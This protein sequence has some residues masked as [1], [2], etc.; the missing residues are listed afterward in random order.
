[1]QVRMERS[2]GWLYL[3]DPL[4]DGPRVAGVEA[5]LARLVEDPE[6]RAIVVAG[7]RPDFCR[8]LDPG[9]LTPAAVDG[10]PLRS[11][12]A[13]LLHLCEA[14]LPTVAAVQGQA[15]GGGVGLAAA[16]DLVLAEPDATFMLPE[17]ILGL[18]PEL[19]GPFVSR[20]LG[21]ART[22]Y[23][24]LSSRGVHAAEAQRIGLVDEVAVDGLDRAVRTQLRR[25]LRSSPRALA[26]CKR[27]LQDPPLEELRAQ[28]A[29]AV[30]HQ[31]AWLKE[32]EGRRG[33]EAF[34]RGE[35]PP[36]FQAGGA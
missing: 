33:V 28:A 2:V 35:R 36:W 21:T 8:G 31:L 29:A 23:L 20:R 5:A 13:C 18:V 30:V 22:R 11:F 24:A 7:A 14:P 25:L 19:I 6:C 32:T 1:V 17:A 26:E 10:A 9:A 16:C 3:E 34:A 15:Q 4:L 27:R 12:V